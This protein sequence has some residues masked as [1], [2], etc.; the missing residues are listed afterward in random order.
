MSAVTVTGVMIYSEVILQA[1][2]LTFNSGSTLL[3][4]PSPQKGGEPPTT[5]T[6]I[7]NEIDINGPA[8][9]IYSF[10]GAPAPAYDP[11]T[12]K[13]PQTGT[14]AGGRDLASRPPGR[15]PSRKPRTAATADRG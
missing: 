10:D 14:A 12:P 7:A 6:I 13:P 2:T 1:T 15:A 11:G 4:A 9:I 5:L 3:L 8:S